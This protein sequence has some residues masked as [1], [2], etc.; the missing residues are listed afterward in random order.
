MLNK[1]S[2]LTNYCVWYGI[3]I[4]TEHTSDSNLLVYWMNGDI[5]LKDNTIIPV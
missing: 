5:I 2:Q 1:I 4:E 3:T